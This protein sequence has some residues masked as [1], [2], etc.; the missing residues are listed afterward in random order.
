MAPAG[1]WRKARA[2]ASRIKPGNACVNNGMLR[3][4]MLARRIY[5]EQLYEVKTNDKPSRKCV[6]RNQRGMARAAINV[7][8]AANET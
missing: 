4:S 2:E 8:A 6:K 7:G 1:M 5:Q 3:Q